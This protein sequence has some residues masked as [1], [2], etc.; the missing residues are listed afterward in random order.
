MKK[1]TME[2]LMALPKESQD[3]I[4]KLAMDRLK[5][6]KNQKSEAL[7]PLDKHANDPSTTDK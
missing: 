3:K 6:E 1:E 5:S 2:K 4:W 7:R